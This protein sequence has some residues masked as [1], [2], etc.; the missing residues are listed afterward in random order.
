MAVGRLLRIVLDDRYAALV[1]FSLEYFLCATCR[2]E[3]FLTHR[4]CIQPFRQCH[5]GY[6]SAIMYSFFSD[7]V[8]QNHRGLRKL[9]AFGKDSISYVFGDEAY[10]FLTSREGIFSCCVHSRTDIGR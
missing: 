9:L 7:T 4:L 1:A 6:F 10:T 8:R 5:R 3:V 2:S